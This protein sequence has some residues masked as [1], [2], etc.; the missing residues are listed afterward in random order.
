IF[1]AGWYT[2]S[3]AINVFNKWFFGR[4]KLEYHYPYPVFVTSCHMLVHTIISF[5]VL[6]SAWPDWRPTKVIS[7]WDYGTK[8]MPCAFAAGVD[9]A[10]TNSSLQYITLSFATMIKSA[11]PIVILFFSFLFGLEQPRF[12]LLIIIVT[13]SAGTALMVF[14][15][16]R[17]VLAGFVS[18]S[19]ATLASGLRWTLTHLLLAKE[20]LGINNPVATNLYLAPAMAICMLLVGLALEGLPRMADK[21][22]ELFLYVGLSGTVAWALVMFEYGVIMTAG[23]LTFSVAG[24]FKEILTI[25]VS[26]L[27]FGDQLQAVNLIGLGISLSGIIAYN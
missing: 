4:G 21:G 14:G 8:I 22:P 24:I 12:A 6:Y 26:H 10:L 27:V 3:T 15:E 20:E 17:F 16:L 11:A 2:L 25:A 19:L 7:G 1:I 9:I 18:A 23:A 5:V 13:I